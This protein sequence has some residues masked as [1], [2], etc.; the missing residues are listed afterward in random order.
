[1]IRKPSFEE[2]YRQGSP[3]SDNISIRS[4]SP[5]LCSAVQNRQYPFADPSR[6]SSQSN[7]TSS[8]RQFTPSPIVNGHQTPPPL[9]PRVP[10]HVPSTRAQTTPP[11]QSQSSTPSSEAASSVHSHQQPQQHHQQLPYTP[12]GNVQQMLKR[13]SPIQT[14][15]MR[16]RGI[17]FANSLQQAQVAPPGGG[18]D[19]SQRGISPQAVQG[20]HPVIMQHNGQPQ[21]SLN[22]QYRNGSMGNGGPRVTIKYPQPPPPYPQVSTRQ[23]PIGIH[24]QGPVSE[25]PQLIASQQPEFRTNSAYET[26]ITVSN[27]ANASGSGDSVTVSMPK[28]TSQ[29]PAAAPVSVQA[30]GKHSPIIMHSVKSREVSKPMPQTA[31]APL[32]PPPATPTPAQNFI[33][34]VQAQINAPAGTATVPSPVA[35]QQLHP[36]QVLT[37]P[38]PMRGNVQIQIRTASQNGQHLTPEQIQL[39][40]LQHTQQQQ[41]QQQQGQRPTIQIHIQKNQTLPT[42]NQIQN[43]QVQNLEFYGQRT[44]VDTPNS[45]PRSGSPVS[46]AT[47]QSPL[48]VLSTNSTPS[49]NSDIPDRPPPPYPGRHVTTSHHNTSGQPPIP[50]RVPLQHPKASSTL[51]QSVPLSHPQ[52][53]HYP[54]SKPVYVQHYPQQ[55]SKQPTN[56]HSLSFPDQHIPQFQ[57]DTKPPALLD[58][59][60]DTPSPAVSE[61]DDQSENQNDEDVDDTQSEGSEKHRCTSPIPERNPEAEKF[62]RLRGEC[63]VRYL[64]PDAF[65]FY[66]EQHVENLMKSHQQR[67]HRR[68]QLENEMAKVGLSEEAQCQMRRMLHQKESNYIRLKRAKMDKQMFDKIKPLGIGAFGEV[69]LVRKKDAGKLYAMKTL[70]KNDVLKRN[71]VAHVKAERD[72]LAE[73]DNE[74]VVKLYYSFQDE[75]NLYFVMDYVP[76]GDLM[77]LLIKFGIFPESLSRFYIAELV[78]AIESVHK[79][80]F[81][82]RDIKPDNILIDRDGHIKLTDFGLCTGFRWTHNSKYYQKGK[83]IGQVFSST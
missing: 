69:T 30:W 41:Q 74:W 22:P 40:H 3:V 75:N 55:Y 2:K 46:R 34:S 73:A 61:R 62:D 53:S 76:G 42:S 45:T 29:S 14:E 10:I 1:M 8:S 9:P 56:P 43:V 70:R 54:A 57:R 65:K 67:M 79:M 19:T 68:V 47:N 16:A 13:M 18:V 80:G 58:P 39:A 25:H 66:M 17:V 35:S 83:S 60:S 36:K 24:I 78:L 4:D 28:R 71:Q 64:S 44:L 21:N 7:S 11:P 6:S 15:N 72:I 33:S 77:G 12:P 82:H 59:Q 63:K 49:S 51:P 31:T 32:S 48:S 52:N 20:R 23:S 38:N 81:I 50:P 5:S 27:S 37:K 26:Q